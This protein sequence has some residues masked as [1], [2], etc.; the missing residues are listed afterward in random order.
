MKGDQHC[1]QWEYW[2]PQLFVE[3]DGANLESVFAAIVE[4][5]AG[6]PFIAR[7]DAVDIPDNETDALRAVALRVETVNG[8]RDLCFAD[9]R[10]DKARRVGNVRVAAEYAYLSV[11]AQGLRHASLTGGTVLEAA[12]LR[13]RAATRQRLAHIVKADYLE[14]TIQ[15]DQAWP[16]SARQQ[17][18]EIGTLPE[19]GRQGYVTAYTVIA[20]KPIGPDRA[21][22]TFLRGADY[23]RSLIKRVNEKDGVAT[24]VIGLIMEQGE[25]VGLRKNWVASNE[26][27]TKFWRADMLPGN[28]A[29]FDYP[30]K[31]RGAPVRESDFAPEGALRL[32]EYGVGDAVRQS[33]YVSVRRLDPRRYEI[34]ANVALSVTFP[35]GTAL[36]LTDE[37]LSQAG[38]TVSVVTMPQ[39]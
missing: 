35:G 24:C 4:P 13:I 26:Q 10:P 23:Y 31:L 21:A 33:T 7:V 36:N 2:I 37:A 30:F 29:T 5:Y 14:K 20:I 34:R 3:R 8:H 18:V 6:R 11:D 27:M 25:M 16:D 19:S 12:G 1:R 39:K 22:I 15:I 9:G 32:W 28:R 38:G 17:L